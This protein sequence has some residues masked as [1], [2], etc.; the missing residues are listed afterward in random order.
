MARGSFFAGIMKSGALAATLIAGAAVPGYAGDPPKL[1]LSGSA[2]FTT[3]YIFRGLSQ[4]S[5]N[6]AV[7][8]EFDL[9][10]GIFYAYIW[11]SNVNFGNNLEIDYGL[12]ITPKFWGIDWNIAGLAYTYP[13]S[14]NPELDYFELRTSAAHTF[15]KLTL[16]IGNWWS[17]DNFNAGT[18]SDAI[19]GGASYAFSGKLWNFFSPSISGAVGY[20]WYENENIFPSYTYWN[21]G[22]TLGFLEHWSADI[23]YWDTTYST[24]DCDFATGARHN[25]DARAVGTIKATF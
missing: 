20:Q 15:N 13:S 19:E 8:P 17:P 1:T 9:T 16:S 18:E 21:A 2:T 25:C 10:Y 3:D 22:L 5:Q 14:T 24:A 23:R 4:T 7:Q 6:P 11:G 12:G